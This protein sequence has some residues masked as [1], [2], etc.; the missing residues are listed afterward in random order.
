MFAAN[1]GGVQSTRKDVSS[2]VLL[3]GGL[4]WPEIS[5]WEVGVP[6]IVAPEIDEVSLTTCVFIWHPSWHSRPT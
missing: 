2:S 5:P 1:T 4:R 3:R 6:S